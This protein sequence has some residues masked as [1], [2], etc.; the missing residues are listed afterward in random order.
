MGAVSFDLCWQLSLI[1]WE[2]SVY[3][4]RFTSP[5]AHQVPWIKV[6]SEASVGFAEHSTRKPT[7]R[8]WKPQSWTIMP[9]GHLSVW[10]INMW[11][12]FKNVLWKRTFEH[13][14]I[15]VSSKQNWLVLSSQAFQRLATIYKRFENVPHWRVY[16]NMILYQRTKIKLIDANTNFFYFKKIIIIR[17]R[18]VW[19]EL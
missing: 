13:W 10:D 2:S 18:S 5:W 9:S 6:S 15:W 16:K 14:Y 1:T 7:G 8:A 3:L 17:V 12:I 11:I 4:K 19:L